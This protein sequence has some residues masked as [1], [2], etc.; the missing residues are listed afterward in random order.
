M[1]WGWGPWVKGGLGAIT[2]P[3]HDHCKLLVHT[4]GAEARA[5]LLLRP[6]RWVQ[7]LP[8]HSTHMA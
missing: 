1:V 4:Q 5:L 3:H 8:V 7:D 6:A 2:A